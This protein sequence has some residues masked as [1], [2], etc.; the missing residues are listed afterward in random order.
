LLRA[1]DEAGVG[2]DKVFVHTTF[3]GGG[4]G[5]GGGSDQLR[6][7]VAVAKTLSGRPVK[8]IWTREEDMRLGEKYRPMGVG[9]FEA[10]LDANGWPLA[11]AMRTTGDRYD[12]VDTPS[13]THRNLVAEQAVRGLHELP[14]HVPVRH[15]VVHTQ[16]SHVPVG[17]RRA[18]G[19]GVNVFYLESFVDELA[20]AAGKDPYEYRRELVARNAHF[21]DRDDW[22][23]ALDMVAEMSGWGT[24]LPEGW[25]RGIAI[26]D[27]RRPSR[28]T[29]A[30]CAEVVTVSVSRRGQLRLER[31]D[32]VFDEGFSLVNPLSVRKQIEGQIAWGFSDT[33]WQEI[34]VKDGRVAEGNFDEYQIARMADYPLEV[35]IQFLK[36]NNKWISGVGE[37]A[38]PQIAPAVAQAVFKITG[39]RIRSL[40]FGNQDLSWG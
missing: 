32:V 26:D 22:L 2:P 36:T 31:V 33:M 28:A 30:L 13:G 18:T 21:R 24:P 9:R 35:N 27:R 17:F 23:K 7:A 4:Y 16:N 29:V 11:I 15:Y 38:I 37:E 39:K 3:L 10:A 34:T 5:G 14:Y 1:A 8:L 12:T 25:A 20:H 19:S 40:P 6:Q